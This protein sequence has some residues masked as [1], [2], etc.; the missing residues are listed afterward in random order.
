MKEDVD[1]SIDVEFWLYKNS[2]NNVKIKSSY[3]IGFNFTIEL[4][5]LESFINEIDKKVMPKNFLMR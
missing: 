4:T 2:F 1:N 3:N 5:T